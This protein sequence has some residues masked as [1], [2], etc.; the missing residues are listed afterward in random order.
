MKSAPANH[1][2][3]DSSDTGQGRNGWLIGTLL[4]VFSALGFLFFRNTLISG[5]S[6]NNVYLRSS[7]REKSPAGREY[8]SALRS[9]YAHSIAPISP[10]A[11]PHTRDWSSV[12]RIYRL[13]YTES[14]ILFFGV[15]TRHG[16]AIDDERLR[17]LKLMRQWLFSTSG[18][19]DKRVNGSYFDFN[20]TEL[21]ASPVY[22]LY[23][24]KLP[25]VM[26]GSEAQ[27]NIHDLGPQY[28]AMLPQLH[29]NVSLTAVRYSTA[30]F[31]EVIK[32][33]KLLLVSPF[34]PLFRQ[35]ILSGNCRRIHPHFPNVSSVAIYRMPYTFL[36]NKHGNESSFFATLSRVCEEIERTIDPRDFDLAV[37][38]AGA[39]SVFVANCIAR[40]FHTDVMTMG[41]DLQYN[42]G[43]VS[44][45]LRNH[46]KTQNITIDRRYWVD[47]I[48]D[49][50]KPPEYMKIE[51]GCYW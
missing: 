1:P 50:Y 46:L 7:L 35:Q 27:I 12:R 44:Q 20:A 21:E 9:L 41:G 30:L 33:R 15:M 22:A 19:Y 8:E 37:V 43:V 45:R 38:S 2:E 18:F 36:N 11:P 26:H 31:H 34:S 16:V 13:G 51:N 49:E 17:F 3:Q 48:P 6:S 42:L 14:D 47:P 5:A 4:L 23:E 10:D 40:K 25:E 28:K 24:E 29:E 39:Y 32:D